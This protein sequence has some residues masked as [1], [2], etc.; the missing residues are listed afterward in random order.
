MSPRRP[1]GSY[2]AFSPLP[3]PQRAAAVV[4]CHIVPDVT[5]GFPLENMMLCVARTFLRLLPA[6]GDRSHFYTLMFCW[7]IRLICMRRHCYNIVNALWDIHY[8]IFPEALAKASI[9]SAP[10]SGDRKEA[11]NVM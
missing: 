9:M 8:F 11:S 3:L 1:V 10:C 4:F 6:D 7:P 2:P 5:A